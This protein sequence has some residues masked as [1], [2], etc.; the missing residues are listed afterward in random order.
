MINDLLPSQTVCNQK[1]EKGK[2]CLSM[3]KRYYPFAGYYN[4]PDKQLLEE[5]RQ[6]YGKDPKLVLLKCEVC[7]AL[8]RLPEALRRKY[9][10]KL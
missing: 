1:N 5:I 10:Q 2:S 7:N 3:I 6:E 8:Y 9:A 4:E